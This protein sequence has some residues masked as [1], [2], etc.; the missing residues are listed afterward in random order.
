[1][2]IE[3]DHIIE[4]FT[5]AC[6][7][8][9]GVYHYVIEPGSSGRQRTAPYPGFIFPIRGKAQ[10]R[11]NGIPYVTEQGKVVH[12]GADMILDKSVLGEERWEYISVFYNAQSLISSGFS[13]NDRHFEMPIGQSARLL[14]LVCRMHHT[15]GEPGA[16]SAFQT[17]VLFRCVL[18]EMFLCTRN[19]TNSEA[20][21][22]YDSAASYIHNHYMERLTVHELARKNGIN[23]NRL[24][25][26]FKK[27]AGIGPGDYL[28]RYRLNQAKELLITSEA[29][30]GEIAASVGYDDALHFSRIFKKR[31][32]V[33]PSEM[34][35]KFQE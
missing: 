21:A 15:F 17:E 28:V 3:L 2:D 22:L 6:C 32:Y 23:Q 26:I 8:V 31:F 13:L 18:E 10:Y 16:L 14:E 35:A 20:R 1:M 33:S 11:F 30:V 5:N 34:R 27:Y 25:Y 4:Y 29:P 19:M 9:A 7:H 24:F 12:G